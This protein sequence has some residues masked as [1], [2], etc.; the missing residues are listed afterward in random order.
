MRNKVMKI[1]QRQQWTVFAMRNI[2]I[3]CVCVSE[4]NVRHVGYKS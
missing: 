3:H 1:N 2:L 4:R